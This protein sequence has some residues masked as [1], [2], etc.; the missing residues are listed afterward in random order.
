MNPQGEVKWY[1]RRWVVVLLLFVVLGPLGLPLLYKSP[2]FS[3]TGK[4]VLTILTVLYT[5]YLVWVTVKSFEAILAF[6]FLP[7]VEEN[8]SRR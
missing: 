5:G 4:W 3:K 7:A 8:F 6:A 2:R 1:Y